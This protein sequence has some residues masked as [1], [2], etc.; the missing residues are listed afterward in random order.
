MKISGNRPFSKALK[1]IRQP[2][3]I[4]KCLYKK[5][6]LPMLPKRI[7]ARKT[8]GKYRSYSQAY[9][10]IFVLEMLGKKECGLYVEIG[11]YDE[12]DHSNTYILETQFRWHG[13]SIEIDAQAA[14]DFNAVRQNKCICVDAT[15]Y[16]FGKFFEESKYPKQLDYLSLDIEPA[17]QTMAV[18]KRLPLDSYRFSV[19]TY[20]HDMYVS[21]PEFMRASRELLQSRGYQL[22]ASN[23]CWEGRNF[24]DW[25]VDP[26]MVAEEIWTKYLSNNMDCSRIFELAGVV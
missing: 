25:Y 15:R 3:L 1:G 6:C 19:I 11:A 13:I 18:L 8:L 20:E 23:V 10:D 17:F 21:G 4:F 22:V 12:I 24:E 26:A 14:R 9:Q 5:F 16:D 2:S 7:R